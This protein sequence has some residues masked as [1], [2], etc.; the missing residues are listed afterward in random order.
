[1]GIGN[2]IV[3]AVLF[4]L[5]NFLIKCLFISRLFRFGFVKTVLVVLLT[6]I[7]IAVLKN[8]LTLPILNLMDLMLDPHGFVSNVL[9]G[10]FFILVSALTDLFIIRTLYKVPVGGWKFGGLVFA[11]GLAPGLFYL[12]TLVLTH[13]K[14]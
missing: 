1:M 12:F 9:L 8:V 5:F 3:A 11:N 14:V 13:L 7:F 4:F 2:I 6:A 10:L